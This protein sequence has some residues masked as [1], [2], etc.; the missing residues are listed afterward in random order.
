MG[1]SVADYAIAYMTYKVLDFEPLF[2]DI[3]TPLIIT[4][5]VLTM[6]QQENTS[7]QILKSHKWLVGTGFASGYRF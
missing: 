6:I 3:H 7:E 4:L 1:I 5:N 2:S